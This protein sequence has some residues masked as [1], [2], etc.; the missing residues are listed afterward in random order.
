MVS[1]APSCWD[2][3]YLQVF[4]QILPV[5]NQGG[6][7]RSSFGA[8]GERAKRAYALSR[9]ANKAFYKNKQGQKEK[10]SDMFFFC[11]Y[12]PYGT[13]SAAP[14]YFFN[15]RRRISVMKLSAIGKKA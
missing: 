4:F 12:I 10:L 8:L 7:R 11:Y 13:D 1:L 2:R 3:M 5:I 6:A 15:R 9:I 14:F